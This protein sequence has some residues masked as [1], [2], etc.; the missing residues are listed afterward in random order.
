MS[1]RVWTISC[2]QTATMAYAAGV[3]NLKL[4]TH[5]KARLIIA[6]ARQPSDGSTVSPGSKSTSFSAALVQVMMHRI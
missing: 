3:V 1:W 4:T 6:H 2:L 5:K